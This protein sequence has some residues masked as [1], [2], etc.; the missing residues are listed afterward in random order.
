MNDLPPLGD[1]IQP[2]LARIHSPENLPLAL[3]AVTRYRERM[4]ELLAAG[5]RAEAERM[6][7]EIDLNVV[8]GFSPEAARK[9]AVNDLAFFRSELAKE[10][11]QSVNDARELL[12]R[13]LLRLAEDEAAEG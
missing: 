13:T 11:H 9:I 6:Q 5:K 12:R 4:Q 10:L 8:A 2:L 1:D 7:R 3:Q